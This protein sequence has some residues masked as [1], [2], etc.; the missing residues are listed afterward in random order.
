MLLYWSLFSIPALIALSPSLAQFSF[1]SKVLL[2]FYAVVVVVFLGLRF[3]VGP[4]WYLYLKNMARFEVMDWKLIFLFGD[5]AYTAINKLASFL[6]FG[7]WFPNV[8]CAAIAMIGIVSFSLKMPNPWMAIAV[9]A[10]YV[11]I[12]LIVNYTRQAAAFGFEMLALVAL[13]KGNIKKFYVLVFMAAAFHKT[14]LFI[15]LF[16]LFIH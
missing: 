15:L 8:V 13:Y 9:A 6:G 14:A 4:D 2:L 7:L 12:V 16:G 11:I 1:Y 3:E 5:P 10:P